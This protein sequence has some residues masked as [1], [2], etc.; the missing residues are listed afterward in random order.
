MNPRQLFDQYFEKCRDE[1]P[2]VEV[3]ENKNRWELTKAVEEKWLPKIKEFIDN[4]EKVTPEEIESGNYKKEMDLSDTE[5]NPYTLK[6]ILQYLDYEQDGMETNG[7]EMDF[8]MDM[9]SNKTGP[10]LTI[11]GCGMT[12]QLKLLVGEE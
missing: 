1:Y 6:K 10:N 8:W 5:L 11:S 3:E 7:W 9:F 4:L 12:Q 2:L